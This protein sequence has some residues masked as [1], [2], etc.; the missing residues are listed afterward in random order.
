MPTIGTVRADHVENAPVLSTKGLENKE[1]GFYSYAFDDSMSLH[2]V[3]WLD[4]SAVTLVSNCTGSFPLDSVERFSKAKKKKISVPRPQMIKLYNNGMGRA[5]LIDA[6][7]A[8]YRIKFKVIKW[9]WANFTNTLGVI[10]GAAWRIFCVTNQDEDQSLPYFLCS[11]VQSYLHVDKISAAPT[12]IIGKPKR[13]SMITFVLQVGVTGQTPLR[14]NDV[15]SFRHAK[16]K[17]EHYVRRDVTLCIK[18]A[19]FKLY[20]TTK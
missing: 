10:M 8:I 13:K 16:V 15:V 17:S 11:L 7:V 19:H 12:Q 9:W 14:T 18:D 3:K 6:A 2:C 20:H 5:N 4:N 1:R